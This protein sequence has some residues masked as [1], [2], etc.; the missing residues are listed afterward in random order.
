MMKT[1]SFGE[2]LIFDEI[3]TKF[4]KFTLFDKRKIAFLA[5]TLFGAC[6]SY[7]ALDFGWGKSGKI[8]DSW[9]NFSKGLHFLT[10]E[11]K[12]ESQKHRNCFGKSL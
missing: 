12:S 1:G 11:K 6:L 3:L 2:K 10:N 5:V 4:T 8:R 9:Q 7:Q